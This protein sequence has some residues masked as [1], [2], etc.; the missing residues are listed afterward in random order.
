M[1]NKMN[2]KNKTHKCVPR[3]SQMNLSAQ[4]FE[5][6]TSARWHNRQRAVFCLRFS[7]DRRNRPFFIP[8]TP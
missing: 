6:Y 7:K 3:N 2:M 5:G 1:Q 8:C 4:E